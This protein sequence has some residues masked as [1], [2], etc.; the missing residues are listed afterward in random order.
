[1]VWRGLRQERVSTQVKFNMTNTC[2]LLQYM[3]W[4][5][6]IKPPGNG[7]KERDE[8]E[9]SCAAVTPNFVYG[10]FENLFVAHAARVCLGC[11]QDLIKSPESHY[12]DPV[13][14]LPTLFELYH[15]SESSKSHLK[16][17]DNL[18]SVQRS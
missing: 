5:D 15:R 16:W 14:F 10:L 17:S 3:A 13:F 9:D 2:V 7:T 12:L 4:R 18:D 8:M 6:G 1:M 11:Y